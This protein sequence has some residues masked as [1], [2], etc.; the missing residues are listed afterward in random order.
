MDV[1]HECVNTLVKI[2]KQKLKDLEDDSPGKR[3]VVKLKSHKKKALLFA[4]P[5]LP[6]AT[7]NAYTVPNIQKGFLYNG[8]LDLETT[9]VPCFRN[10]LNT[11]QGDVAGTCLEDRRKLIETYFE[12]MYFT[13][14]ILEETFDKNHVPVDKDSKDN[15]VLKSNDIS[16]E[17]RHRAKILTSEVQRQQRRKLVNDTRIKDYECKKKL[18]DSEQHNADLNLVCESKLVGI[19]RK[20]MPD[21][22]LMTDARGEA[23]YESLGGHL[24]LDI[25]NANNSSVLNAELKAFV[26]VRSKRAL[27]RVKISYSNV[28][29]SKELLL[30]RCFELRS[31][32]KT[33]HLYTLPVYP[34]LM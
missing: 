27:K 6:A 24:T 14:T 30:K 3:D 21:L 15:P 16:C 32:P 13:G 28:P 22:P 10:L 31:A 18:Y 4:L 5:N 17:N 2:V 8:Q 26:K 9:S 7:G 29:L 1:P 25:L 33:P 11:F 34:N 20:S 12:E 23:K 19:I